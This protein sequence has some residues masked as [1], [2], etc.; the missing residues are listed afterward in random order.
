LSFYEQN[1]R[2]LIVVCSAIFVAVLLH[3][4]VAGKMR[5]ESAA[6]ENKEIIPLEKELSGRIKEGKDRQTLAAAQ[7]D[8]LAERKKLIRVISSLDAVILTIPEDSRFKVPASRANDASF[9]FQEQL[10]RMR[11]EKA[12]TGQFPDKQPLGFTKALQNK[13]KPEALLTRLAAVERLCTAVDMAGL[14]V[15]KIGHVLTSGR[16]SVLS[17]AWRWPLHPVSISI[18][19][20]GNEESL[21]RFI[22]AISS[23][24]SFMALE[25]LNLEVVDPKAGV[26]T[27][28]AVVSAVLK[29]KSVK[30]KTGTATGAARWRM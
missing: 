13:N 30:S 3:V 4:M 8:I 2:F 27:I 15:I 5:S 25:T 14:R 28:S 24:G 9:Y 23:K 11:K 26:I 16:G 17:Q 21:M 7:K 18:R 29:R 22:E 20:S 6:I 12:A 19:A 10:D 1:K